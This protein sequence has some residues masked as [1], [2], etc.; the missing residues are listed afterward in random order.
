[1]TPAAQG[2]AGIAPN[3][4]DKEGCLAREQLRRGASRSLGYTRCQQHITLSL[5][6]RLHCF[7]A[8]LLG[9]YYGATERK[10][11]TIS[12]KALFIITVSCTEISKRWEWGVVCLFVVFL[13][14]E[15]YSQ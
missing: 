13:S 6:F 1:M 4:S 3:L 14:G 9:I 12:L 15:G 8:I 2:E 10:G 11:R 5:L 7:M